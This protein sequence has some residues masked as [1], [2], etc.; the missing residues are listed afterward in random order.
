MAD[1]P[2]PRRRFQFRLRTLMIGVTVFCVVVGGYVGWQAKIVRERRALL[3]EINAAGGGEVPDIA[4]R[5][6]WL[7][8]ILG[9]ENV[10]FMVVPYMTD[11]ETMARI[12][13]LFPDVPTFV[14]HKEHDGTIVIENKSAKRD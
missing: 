10:G 14:G 11:G 8:R 5:P 6:P 3:D 7:R 13:R 9:D 2:S 12:F 4:H 1:Q